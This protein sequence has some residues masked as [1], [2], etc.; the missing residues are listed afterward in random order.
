MQQNIKSL[1]LIVHVIPL[2]MCNRQ[3]RKFADSILIVTDPFKIHF[4]SCCDLHQLGTRLTD[5]TKCNLLTRY[6]N[7]SS[8]VP[9]FYGCLKGL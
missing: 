4:L 1:G 2:A 8:I 3:G 9:T 7:N 6:I 5:S